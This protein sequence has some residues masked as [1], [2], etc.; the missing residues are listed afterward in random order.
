MPTP[1]DIGARAMAD[2]RTIKLRS[3]PWALACARWLALRRVSPNVISL[4]SVAAAG[5]GALS[6]LGGARSAG[7]QALC[8]FVLA[9]GMVLLRLFLNMLDGLV[10]VEFGRAARNGLLFNEAPDRVS[11][12]L[13]LAAAGY[14]GGSEADC[15][16]GWLCAVLALFTAFV[17]ILARPLGVPQPFGG[18]M[19]KQQR[20]AIVAVVC[21]AAGCER[22]TGHRFDLFGFALAVIAI[23]SAE[24][25][26]R[27]LSIISRQAQPG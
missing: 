16:L 12:T 3:A 20:M 1:D 24:T 7:L 26:R 6:M 9:A 22:L 13:V 14:A 19:A 25:V 21:V 27:R 8:L 5:L 10:A 4:L 18:P 15:A 17:R 2:R 23:G 11:D